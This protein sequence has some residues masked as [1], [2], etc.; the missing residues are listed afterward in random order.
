MPVNYSDVAIVGAGPYGLSLAA[1]L[2]ARGVSIRVFGEPMMGWRGHMPTG[3]L[4][5]SEGFASNLY[6]P[7][8]SMTLRRY[9][10]ERGLPYQDIG[11][12]VPL[13][14]F[15][16][17]GLAFQ[18]EFVPDLDPSRVDAITNVVDGFQLTTAKR[19][20]FFAHRLVVAAGISHFAW[21][22]PLLSDHPT[23][24]VSHSS[25]HSG[26]SEF[27][28]HRVA[29][30]GGGASAIDLAALLHE[31]GAEVT[32]ITRRPTPAFHAPPTDPRPLASRLL[33]PR[34][35]LGLGW[36]SW[37]C[38]YAPLVFH[39]APP[40]LRARVVASHLGPAPGWFMKDRVLGRF[41]LLAASTVS[42]L[43]LA[44]SQVH[45][46]IKDQTA[47]TTSITVDHVIGATGYRVDVDRLTFIE[48]TLRGRIRR[49]H[50][51]PM[52]SRNFE[53]S[54][55]GLFMIGVAAANSFGPLM[56]FACGAR[57]TARRLA[58]RL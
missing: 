57:F 35:P 54:V 28:H 46:E 5:K 11:L 41:P 48:A 50:G 3:M 34:S 21:L 27:R 36:R 12:P 6:D 38:T 4:L 30:I 32:L 16:A 37:L 43:N 31:N 51:A 44:D 25:A 33:E 20:T 49:A 55:P 17:Y 23:E 22:P 39:H 47:R 40:D 24:L 58:P 15:V 18:Q 14:I 45:L 26:L 2:R 56:R 8:S 52:L 42:A 13:A 7:Q 53:T 19:E 1:Y 29:V 10:D 9:C